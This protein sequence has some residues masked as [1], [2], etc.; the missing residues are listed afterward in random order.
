[1]ILSSKIA[2]MYS[3]MLFTRHDADGSI[4]YFTHGDFD[5]LIAEPFEFNNNRGDVLRGNFYSYPDAREDTL[6]V[7]DH[8]MGTGH[9]AY[10]R[11][12]EML[13]RHGYRVFSYDHTGCTHSD[14]KAIRGFAGSL[15]DLDAAITALKAA[16]Q[17]DGRRLVVMG[18]SWGGFSTMNIAAYHPDVEAIVALSGF[19][20]VRTIQADNLSGILAL[21]RGT[22]W[23]LEEAENPDYVNADAVT[24]LAGTSARALIIHSTDDKTVSYKKHFGRLSK[25]L[26]GR[27]N[28]TLLTVTGKGHNPNFTAEAVAY[29]DKFFAEHTAAK[30]KNALST[31]EEKASFVSSY[32]WYKMTEQDE[33]LWQIIFDHI[34]K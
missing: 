11:E 4:F 8:G 24:T 3:G 21:W 5:G 13:A 16:E 1:M 25:A 32:N 20:S 9:T 26:E 14:G 29:K 6:V 22:V 10:M 17:L 27:N 7:F 33:K 28:V 2:A 34:D 18:H 31:S 19:T 30:K 12:I 15:S 23:Q